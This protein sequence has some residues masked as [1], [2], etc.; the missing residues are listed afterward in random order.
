[1]AP[2]P[3]TPASSVD[4]LIEAARTIRR[5]EPDCDE[6]LTVLN[7][8]QVALRELTAATYE[9]AP[10][11][12]Q[13]TAGLSREERVFA[14]AAVHD[15]AATIGQAS[16]RCHAAGDALAPLLSRPRSHLAA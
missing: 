13:G 15:L 8:L 2:P 10:V 9:L 7:G 11:V 1:M 14:R 3:S 5:A 16:R 4:G 6:A 12:G